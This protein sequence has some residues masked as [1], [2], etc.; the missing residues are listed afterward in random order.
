MACTNIYLQISFVLRPLPSVS[1]LKAASVSYS[2]Q[3][4]HLA[5]VWKIKTAVRPGMWSFY[6]VNYSPSQSNWVS[7]SLNTRGLD[8]T[9]SCSLSIA[10]LA[11]SD[12]VYWSYLC[13]HTALK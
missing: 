10:A 8:L 11:D 9:L 6:Y 3:W 2:Q 4:A 12:L 1:K 13:S 7:N 5:K